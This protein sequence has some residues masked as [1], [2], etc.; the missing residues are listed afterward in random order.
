MNVK[1]IKDK[2]SILKYNLL[3]GHK[4]PLLSMG[5]ILSNMNT[6]AY[7]SGLGTETVYDK[8]TVTGTEWALNS[9]GNYVRLGMKIITGSSA[10]G[11]KI[12]KVKLSLKKVNSPTGN[13]VVRVRNSSDTIIA[14]SGNLDVSTLTTSF[15]EYEFTLDTVV[16]LADGDRV[17][18][19]YNTS[20]DPNS[21]RV[22]SKAETTSTGFNWTGY[23]ASYSDATTHNNGMK[24]DSDPS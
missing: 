5:L 16:T 1:I 9:S 11:K 15:A 22:Q 17:M 18:I 3:F 8:L 4:I 23:V 14:F 7:N 12:Y 10:I 19:E 20:G 13:A 2:I 24:F 21:I 6:G